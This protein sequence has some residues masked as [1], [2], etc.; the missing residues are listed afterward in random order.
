MEMNYAT[1]FL[2]KEVTV[3][4]DHPMG[5]VHPEFGHIYSLNYGFVDLVTSPDGDGLDAYVLGVFEPIK[6]FTGKCIAVV[7]RKKEDDD[8]L[9]VVP[10]GISYSNEQIKALIEFQERFFDSYIVRSV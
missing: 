10:H 1:Q 8:K 3:D 7:K 5:S 4:V 6:E 9:I 2:G